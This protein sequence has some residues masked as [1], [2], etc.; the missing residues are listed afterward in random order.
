MTYNVIHVI[1][2]YFLRGNR[3]DVDHLFYDCFLSQSVGYVLYSRWSVLFWCCSWVSTICR[4]YNFHRNDSLQLVI[5]T[6][7]VATIIQYIWKEM[8]TIFHDKAPHDSWMGYRDI[9]SCIIS[10]LCN[11]ASSVSIK[12]FIL[13]RVFWWHFR[14]VMILDTVTGFLCFWFF[15]Y[16]SL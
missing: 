5:V 12:H 15:S 3:E 7:M 2:W 14:S 8:N 10:N 1:H 6:L 9:I 4:L 13:P 16:S 11:M